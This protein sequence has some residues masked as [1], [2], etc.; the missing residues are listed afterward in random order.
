MGL[1]HKTAEMHIPGLGCSTS[2][3]IKLDAVLTDVDGV[4]EN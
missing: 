1:S 3:C 4:C 2:E